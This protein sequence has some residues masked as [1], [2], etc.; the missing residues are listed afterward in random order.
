[1]T[2]GIVFKALRALRS[3]LGRRRPNRKPSVQAKPQQASRKANKRMAIKFSYIPP[4]TGAV[5]CAVPAD[6]P[7]RVYAFGSSSTEV[8]DYIFG[9]SPRY[10]SYWAGGWS[11]RGLR[12]EDNRS[13]VLRCLQG[14]APQD[15]I[16]LHFGVVDAL[17]NS[18]YRMQ[19][20]DFMD[21]EGF[22]QEAADGVAQLA[23]DLK[24]AGFTN[25][26]ALCVGAP[27]R[28]S[29][30]YFWRRFKLYGLPLR[31][32]AQL[33]NRMTEL[34]GQR[35]E[36]R[37][38][39]PVLADKDGL[40]KAK[41]LRAKIN[42]HADYSKIQKLVWEGIRDIPGLPPHRDT[43]RKVLYRSGARGGVAQRIKDKN[44]GAVD[45]SQF[46]DPK[47]NQLQKPAPKKKRTGGKKKRPARA[48]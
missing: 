21:P 19:N 7:A 5:G 35:C 22:C 33:L 41:F 40:M 1:M 4:E 24:A 44:Y 3:T 26:Y 11:A 31:Y 23:D 13:Y 42:H 48:A 9:S 15:I 6:R 25:V 32:Q 14:A 47:F 46:E 43:W 39:S 37:D 8:L 17:F 2:K 16:F 34:V 36:L 29:R 45:L 10:R 18:S 27:C 38:L 28:V 20:G 12:K 30:D